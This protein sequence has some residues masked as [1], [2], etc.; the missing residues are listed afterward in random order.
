MDK[1][2]GGLVPATLTPKLKGTELKA[3]QV[4]CLF[5]P[6]EYSITKSN[7]YSVG[8]TKGK[9]IPKIDFEQGGAMTLKLS[10]VFDTYDEA[11]KRGGAEDVTKKHT[12]KIWKMM[13]VHP[14][15]IDPNTEKGYPPHCVFGWGHYEFE[16]VI[17]QMTETLTLFTKDGV[18]VR[19]KMQMSLQQIVDKKGFPGKQNPTS[20]GGVA[21][22]SR[23]LYA[24]D[25]LDLIAWQE[26][27]DCSKWRLI[28]E[29]NEGVDPLHLRS[30]RTIVIPPFED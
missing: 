9:N 27:G 19:S 23:V 14:S 4:P 20:G 2:R 15:T 28:A 5:N 30:G 3:D 25:R 8:D 22:T 6:Y 26:Y 24:G 13:M 16:G 18:P 12:N 7:T 10:L 17:T 29:A 21:P 1:T 11:R